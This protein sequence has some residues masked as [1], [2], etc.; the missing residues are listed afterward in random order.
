MK[1]FS[2]FT[3]LTVLVLLFVVSIGISKAEQSDTAGNGSAVGQHYYQDSQPDDETVGKLSDSGEANVQGL[4]SIDAIESAGVIINQLPNQVNGYYSDASCDLGFCIGPQQVMADNF[5]L[6]A[7]ESIAQIV[8]W[9]GYH[10]GDVPV[11]PDVFTVIFHED[12]AG[13]PGAALYTETNVAYTRLQTGIVIFGVHEWMYVLTLSEPV[14]IGPGTYWVEVYND[15]GV[16]TDDFFW[17]TGNPDTLGNGIPGLAQA[18]TAPGSGWVGFPTE[19]AFQLITLDELPTLY[20]ASTGLDTGQG[21]SSLYTIDHRTG[22]ATLVG[23]IGFDNVTGLAFLGDGR[24]VGSARG[25]VI[26]ATSATT[27]ILIEIDPATGAGSLIGTI[28]DQDSGCGRMPD[29]SYDPNTDTLYGYGDYCNTDVEGLFTIDPVT[30]VGTPVGPSGYTGGGNGMDV[31]PSTGIIYATPFDDESLITI[32]SATGLGT[33]VPGSAGLVPDRVN[34]LDFHPTSEFLYGSWNDSVSGLNYLVLISTLDGTTTVIGETVLGL[35]AIAFAAPRIEVDPLSLSSTH[36][37]DETTHQTLTI[38][39]VGGLDLKWSFLETASLVSWSGY[40]PPSRTLVENTDSNVG[41]MVPT[42]SGS[43]ESISMGPGP[44]LLYAPSQAD[45]PLWRASLAALIRGRVDY[46]DARS[47]TPTLVELLSYDAVLTWADFSYMDNVAFGDVLADYVDA[48]GQVILSAFTTFTTGN[49]LSGRIMTA[50]YAPVT[51]PTGLNH[52][53]LDQYAGDGTT[54][55]HDGVDFY[56]CAYRDEL[57]LQGSGVQDGSYLDGEIAVSYHPD[58]KVIHI[59]GIDAEPVLTSGGCNGDYQLIIANALRE[60]IPDC[61]VPWASTDPITGTTPAGD[62]T[63]VNVTFDSTGLLP[64]VYTGTLCIES[65]D[66]WDPITTVMV[67]TIVELHKIRL[68]LVL[69]QQ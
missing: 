68:P 8:L 55:L 37:M 1:R 34:A 35:D 21:L 49:H 36:V 56:Q 17:E 69:R 45:D 46:Y 2:I 48:G 27:A 22:A 23:P 51:S 52:Y 44:S 47:G 6:P 50:D 57:A 19:L 53:T 20:G 30:G 32:D 66:A 67:E 59:N 14:S 15:T 26:T 54:F 4:S 62:T 5:V 13:L 18:P 41:M 9:G 7:T 42:Q 43:G 64:G 10:P 38:S 29:I 24:L 33:E 58:L 60:P 63:Q 25:D 40:T 12:D 31:Q 16:G 39:N 28:S 11:D 65:N 61:G 3:P